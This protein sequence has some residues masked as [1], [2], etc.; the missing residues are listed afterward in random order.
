[1]SDFNITTLASEEEQKNRSNLLSL[2]RDNPVPDNE[3]IYTSSLFLKRQ[4]LSKILFFNELYQK[5][6]HLQGV[7]MEFGCRWGQNLVT[8][9]NLRG[10]YEPYNYNRKIIGFDTFEGFRNTTEK[11]GTDQ[12][13]Q[14]G[15]LSVTPE[16]EN[17]LAK[18]LLAHERE[19]P[20]SHIS[21]NHVIKGNAPVEL[22]KYLDKNPQTLIAFA[23]FDFDLYKP[24]LECL[25]IIK[26][27]L[28]KGAIIGFDE[29]NDPKF[30]G[31]T[32]ALKEFA[33]INSLKV[34]RNRY[35]GMQSFIEF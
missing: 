15:N 32:V 17:Y 18:V 7:I 3:K 2:Y 14:D 19:C 35:S 25:E 21:K 34:Q 20:L 5:I 28:I 30:P 12:I 31:E 24:T 1:M 9:N 11:D 33:E 26:P 8:F 23:W 13:I 22:G 6:L 16:Y 27:H 29:L 10:I 4:E